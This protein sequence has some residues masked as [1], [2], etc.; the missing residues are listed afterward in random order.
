MVAV[1]RVFFQVN[2]RTA[3]AVGQASGLA[4]AEAVAAGCRGRPVLAQPGQ[5]GGRRRR[6]RRQG[7]RCSAWCRRCSAWPPLPRPADAA[8]AAALALC[9][10]AH[11]PL[12][13]A[14][15]PP[16]AAADAAVIGSLRGTL[17]ERALAGEVLV[18]VGG[19]RLPG[20]GRRRPPR[21]PLGDLGAEVFVWIHHHVREDAET[22]YGFATRDE[23][24][25]FEALHRR[26]RRR[27][28][29]W[30]WPS[31]RCTRPTALRQVLA[32]DDVAALCLVPGVGKKTAARLLVELKSPARPA[33]LGDGV[34]GARPAATAPPA[35]PRPARADV[36]DA[37]AGL[38]YGA[39]RDRARP[40]ATCPTATTPA[41]LLQRGA[42][43]ASAGREVGDRA[44][45]AARRP[46]PL[47]EPSRRSDEVG[48]R[49]RRSTSSSA[50]PSSRS[51]WRSS[52][53][54]PA[55]G[56]RPPTT[57]SS[58]GRPAWAR[59]R[60]AGIVATEMGVGLHVTS[61]PALERA[62]DLAAD[63][64]QLDE[65]DVLF[66]D[67]IHR[68]SRA[69]E[70]VLYPAMEDF[71]L[72]IV[73]GKGPAAR[74]IRLDLPRFTLV[75]ATTRT[76]LDH[77][78]AAR[79]LRPRRPARLLRARRPRG[80]RRA[81]R[82]HPRRAGR[83]PTGAARSPAGPGARPA[84]PT[85]CCAGCATSPRCGATASSTADAAEA[86]LALFGVDERGLDK[87]DRAI[88]AR[89]L[90]ALRRRPGRAVDA[91]HQRRRA[92]PRPSRT[93]TSRSSSSEGLLMRT[94][95]GR[96]A[97]PGGLGPPRACTAPRRRPPGSASRPLRVAAARTL[98][99]D[100]EPPRA[101]RLQ[102]LARARAW[103][104]RSS[105]SWSTAA[106]ASWPARPP[107][108]LAE[109][110]EGHPGG[111]HPKAKHELFECTI[112]I[113][114]GVCSTVAEARA[115]LEAHPG[116]G[117]RGGRPPGPGPSCARARTRSPAGRTRRSAPNP[118]YARLVD[119]MQWMAR[120]LQIFGVHVHVGVRSPE[121]A[122]AIANALAGYIPHLL[123]LSA[124]SPYWEGDD[125]GLA[126]C[127]SKVFEGLPTAGLPA[128][129]E[130]WAGLRAVHG[131]ARVARRPSARSARSGGTSARTPTSAPSSCGCATASRRCRRCAAVAALAQSLVGR[132]STPSSTAAT[133][134]PATRTG[135]CARTSGGPGAT[136][137][138]P[139]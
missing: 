117:A 15:P 47:D 58:P 50:R 49:P 6:R 96:V 41:S 90:R 84:S 40:P 60:L 11:A 29:R 111:E 80:H 20:A 23:R 99:G 114:T 134:C 135:C 131:D 24:V 138:T 86:G 105:S 65:G 72:D 109:L 56:A 83:P 26:P 98:R 137:S 39:R 10:L 133:R 7:R 121:K 115:D 43:A 106:P 82:R 108:I 13:R 62:G 78:P 130:N 116:R 110:G 25:C 54:R 53:R 94:P 75:G 32:D 37:L 139:T 68:L 45:R 48:L 76:G 122:V 92:R 77:R 125:T 19:R 66:I 21:S 91:R 136:A 79:P 38:G 107:T 102:Q 104:S 5:A 87:V 93:S 126:S 28:R 4:M 14:S 97:T 100:Q 119:E 73:L 123:A 89:A 33:R 44:R 46:S 18:E 12:R 113:I 55:A 52:S 64:R 124:S 22:L 103:A 51:T 67:E 3:M 34:A 81:G 36:R 101:D 17:L 2:V 61:G 118:R 16:R 74:S 27:A 70:E 8:D 57:C 30:P 120:R 1:E 31:C 35:R 88:L 132:T 129:I 85:G 59:P 71:Q 128:P 95:R 112:E 69:V 63:P 127:R 9:H 42:A